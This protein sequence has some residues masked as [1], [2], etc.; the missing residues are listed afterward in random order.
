MFLFGVCTLHSPF[1]QPFEAG[2]AY[3]QQCSFKCMYREDMFKTPEAHGGMLV[4]GTATMMKPSR[5]DKVPTGQHGKSPGLS[6]LRSGMDIY[7]RRRSSSR[8]RLSRGSGRSRSRR[9][10]RSGSVVPVAA[11]VVAAAV[12]VVTRN[13]GNTKRKLVLI[14]NTSVGITMRRRV[15]VMVV[16]V[17]LERVVAST[18]STKDDAGIGKIHS[19]SLSAPSKNYHILSLTQRIA[20]KA[21][22]MT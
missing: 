21:P 2:G 4:T 14:S 19:K 15:V 6:T 22:N 17:V 9:S 18:T 10:R 12:A 1:R 20:R 7:I 13:G 5:P 3:I 8:R 16:A 11:A